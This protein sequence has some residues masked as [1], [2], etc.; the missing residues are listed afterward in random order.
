MS[1]LSNSSTVGHSTETSIALLGLQIESTK[2]EISAKLDGISNLMDTRF[3]VLERDNIELDKR[4]TIQES[5]A[6][7]FEGVKMAL[8]G[9]IGVISGVA[10]FLVSTFG[11]FLHL[12]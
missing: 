6:Y 11:H 12:K 4:M 8:Y 10:S 5:K 3:S 9:I 7:K 1:E 2:N